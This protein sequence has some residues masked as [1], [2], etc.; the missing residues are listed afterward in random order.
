VQRSVVLRGEEE[1]DARTEVLICQV[2][3]LE[4]AGEV[5]TCQVTNLANTGEIFGGG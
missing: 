2:A 5:L 3:N 4:N 1:L